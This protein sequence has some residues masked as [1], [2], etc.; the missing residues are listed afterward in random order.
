[1]S[2]GR[3]LGFDCN[4]NCL[5]F[6]EMTSN[7]LRAPREVDIISVLQYKN[8]CEIAFN[9]NNTFEVVHSSYAVADIMD[10]ISNTTSPLNVGIRKGR[11]LK[12]VPWQQFI[13]M[14]A[15]CTLNAEAVKS[16]L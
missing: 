9:V 7:M 8:G 2:N 4:G 12:G 3:V 15:V 1:M 13:F 5:G 11:S 6:I 10:F 14:Y 16:R